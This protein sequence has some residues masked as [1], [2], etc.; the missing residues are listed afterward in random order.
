[1]GVFHQNQKID[2][3]VKGGV[4][5]FVSLGREAQARDVRK[6]FFCEHVAHR[7]DTKIEESYY[8]SQHTGSFSKRRKKRARCADSYELSLRA[9]RKI[10]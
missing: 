6:Q 9:G 10:I 2:V 8:K 7:V 5:V 1:M 3:W 4:V